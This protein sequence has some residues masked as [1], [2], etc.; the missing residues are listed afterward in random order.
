MATYSTE[1]TLFVQKALNKL[2]NN[3]VEDGLYGAN[4]K[5]AIIAYQ[6][7]KGVLPTGIIDSDLIKMLNENTAVA[8]TNFSMSSFF[9]ENGKKLAIGS[10]VVA[11]LYGVWFVNKLRKKTT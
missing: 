10:S 11:I 1:T 6:K 4:T 3:L 7:S 9:A 5:N 2:G 8:T